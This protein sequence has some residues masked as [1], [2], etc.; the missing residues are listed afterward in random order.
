MRRLAA[1]RRCSPLVARRRAAAAAATTASRQH[2]RATRPT[3]TAD[4]RQRA[5]RA[6]FDGRPPEQ[7]LEL[8]AAAAAST[9]ATDRAAG[10]TDARP[11][12]GRPIAGRRRS[13]IGNVA[14][15]E[16]AGSSR[17][18]L[19]QGKQWLKLDLDDARQPAA[20]IDLER[21]ARREPD[22]GGRARLAAARRRP[23]TEVGTETVDGVETTHYRVS[24]DL[25]RAAKH[26]SGPTQDA[27]QGVIA[28][29]GVTTL[30]LDVWVDENGYVR[31]VSYDEHAGRRAGARQLTMKLAR[32]RRARST[33]T[34]PPRA[35]R[36]ST[37]RDDAIGL[38]EVALKIWRFDPQTGERA[39]REY[40]VDAPEW[41]T[42]LDVLDID[43]GQARRDA[44]VP[45][46]LPDDDLRLVRDA[47]G[48][49]RGAR[50]QD[51]DVRR[52][53]GRPRAGD[54]G[55]GQPAVV[56]DLVVDMEPFW[57]KIRAMKPWLEPGYDEAAREGAPRLAGAD[58]RRSTRS[59]SASTAAA[60][61]RSATRWSP[62]RSSSGRPALAKGDALRR[63]RR[64]TGPSIER[65]ERVQRRS[66]GSGTARAATSAT[67]A[68]RRAS[69]RA[70]RSPSSA[71]SRS[72]RA[73]TATWARS[74]RS[75]SSRRRETTG[76]LRET[77]L[78]P[79]TQGIVDG[80]QADEVRAAS[81][82]STA[83]C[84]RRSRRTWPKDVKESRALLRPR[85][86]SRAAT[87][88]RDR[89]GRA[90]ARRGSSSPSE[91]DAT[92]DDPEVS[93]EAR[94]GGDRAE[95]RR[96]L[97]GLP[98]LALG[99]GARHLDAGARAEGRPRAGRARVGHVLRRRRH[100]RGRARLLPPPERAH[101]RLRGGDRLPTR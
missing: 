8:D 33:S 4:G 77:E 38:M 1:A 13:S 62:T 35:T 53:R 20:G 50:L 40:E 54:L 73:S 90:G 88:R 37:R 52:S 96:L 9:H 14:L 98:R 39:L 25:D 30:P 95:A 16:V 78:V 68:A 97:Q 59:R 75:G 47:H 10:S 6:D 64:A 82:P 99:E 28:Q 55:D 19:P 86:G 58:E 67:S 44:R 29:S 87:A 11:P 48:R 22:A 49:R 32:L 21:H 101:P 2:A 74:T 72:R 63:R 93:Q 80:D 79:K 42:L 26:A 66:T 7:A 94:V 41:V 36:S 89:P 18:A 31:K 24:I 61:S 83:R 46:E 23:V 51:A 81:S 60:A 43:Q 27:L 69:T 15:D 71:P 57:A 85:A 34:P 65:L 76:W 91:R 5:R 17:S 45:Q 92:A 12:S 3:T 56:K 84:R 70:T 100:P